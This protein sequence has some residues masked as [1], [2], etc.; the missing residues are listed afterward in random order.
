[1]TG[2]G[3]AFAVMLAF[4]FVFI[5]QARV[6]KWPKG[7]RATR[8]TVLGHQV[9]II[10]P[11]GSDGEK[12][13]LIDACATASVSLF[14]AWRT[15]RPNDVGGEVTWPV[16]GVRFVDDAEMD[17]FESLYSDKM[18]FAYLDEIESRSVTVPLVV[19]RKSC[20][21]QLISEGQPLMHE[22]L[23]LMLNHFVPT[24][25][26]IASGTHAAWDFVQGA[27]VETFRSLYSPEAQLRRRSGPP[28]SA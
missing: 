14:T 28:K 22:L 18:V 27:A 20:A 5:A 13:L 24:E 3:A 6:L 8:T 11:P 23:R 21:S 17:Q 7:P 2:A 19:I 9:V 25:P 10:N 26:G 12:L 4:A 16:I 1:V 15:W